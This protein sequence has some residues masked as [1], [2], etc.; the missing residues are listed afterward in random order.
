MFR[1][2]SLT[3]FDHRRVRGNRV[4]SCLCRIISLKKTEFNPGIQGTGALN[5]ADSKESASPAGFLLEFSKI[6][7]ILLQ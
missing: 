6:L 3:D 2:L 1:S 4:Q 7:P 5:I